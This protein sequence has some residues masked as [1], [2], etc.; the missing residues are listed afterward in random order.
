MSD[1]AIPEEM[2]AIGFD[3]PG[4]PEVLKPQSIA[5]PAPGAEDVLIRVAY[6]GVNRPDCA[7]RAGL[8]RLRAK[9]L[10]SE[11]MCPQR[12]LAR[13]SRR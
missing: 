10:R 8:W 1:F 12:C 13:A 2:S 6:A 4:G 9:W 7:Q 11:A 3:V 5:V